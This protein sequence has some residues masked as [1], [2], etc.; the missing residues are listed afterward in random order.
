MV[1]YT[2][3]KVVVCVCNHKMSTT[4][5]EVERGEDALG[6]YKIHFI[7]WLY[8]IVCFIRFTL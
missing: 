1:E 3:A 6:P 4:L 7:G 8:S 5:E 2:L